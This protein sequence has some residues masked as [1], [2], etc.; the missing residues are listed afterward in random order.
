MIQ[1]VLPHYRIPFFVQLEQIL[2]EHGI[3]LHL[4]YGDEYAGTVPR[5]VP[6]ESPWTTYASNSYFRIGTRELIWQRLPAGK[7]QADLLIVEQANRLLNNY[8]F[9][10]N[11]RKRKVAFFGHGK[12]MQATSK[13]LAEKFKSRLIKV[14]DW[15]FAYT[16][17]SR[18]IIE[19]AGFPSERITTVQNTIDAAT[20]RSALNRV[21]RK[22]IQRVR[23]RHGLRGENIGLFCGG[24]YREKRI[25]FLLEAS[26]G[27]RRRL[28]DFELIIVGDGPEAAK[29]A[30]AA[31]RF[32]WV[33]PVGH[34]V[35]AQL[36]PYLRCAKV[37]LMPG[38]VGLVIIDSFVAGVPLVTTDNGIHSPEIAYLENG[39]NGL[40][41]PGN[42]IA[43][44]R[45]V[46]DYLRS[47]ALQTKLGQGCATSAQ[48]L[49][50][51]NMVANF[52]NGVRRCLRA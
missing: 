43:Y 18:Q 2:H 29:V 24:L 20:L 37:L 9:L 45:A 46:V 21:D 13:P 5:T 52:A 12:N 36:A 35:G 4:I 25:D 32:D 42:E 10:L 38:L 50:M 33:H 39:R 8:S 11:R 49:T 14:V 30:A 7:L 23:R 40:I 41:T 48:K 31:R 27:I 34:C 16:D 3:A 47:D 15:W 22:E 19:A 6:L 17:I 26:R 28:H 1:R 51:E 44:A